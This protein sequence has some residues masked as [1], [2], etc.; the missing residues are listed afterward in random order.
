[1]IFNYGSVVSHTCDYSGGQQ[2]YKSESQG[3]NAQITSQCGPY[4]AGWWLYNTNKV[5]GYDVSGSTICKN[6]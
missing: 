3:A 1:M 6:M 5:Y 4:K 2:C